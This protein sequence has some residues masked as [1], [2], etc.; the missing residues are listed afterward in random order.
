MEVSGMRPCCSLLKQQV[1]HV[2]RVCSRTH[3]V[4]RLNGKVDVLLVATA[5][6]CVTVAGAGVC[7]PDDYGSW[8]ADAGVVA[9]VLRE[10]C[11]LDARVAGHL[12]AAPVHK[13]ERKAP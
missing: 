6:L 4:E 5:P 12:E 3:R 11:R 2:S 13:Q 1:D 8:L 10:V 7:D 9:G